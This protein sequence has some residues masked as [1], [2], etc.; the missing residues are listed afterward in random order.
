VLPA[1]PPAGVLP[2]W[3][4]P[5]G[6]SPNRKWMLYR[7]VDRSVKKQGLTEWARATR[8]TMNSSG[9]GKHVLDGRN[10]DDAHPLGMRA[11]CDYCDYR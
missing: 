2:I 7:E 11:C 1:S 10:A 8:S 3:R 5:S 4:R 6:P 9:T